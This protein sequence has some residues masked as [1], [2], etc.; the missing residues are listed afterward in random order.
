MISSTGFSSSGAFA[1]LSRKDFRV[2]EKRVVDQLLIEA[3]KRQPCTACGFPGGDAHHV[4]SRGAGG[5]DVPS[6]LM[7]LCRKHH[8]EVHQIGWKKMTQKWP[9][10]R[11]WLERNGR[12]DI[13]ERANR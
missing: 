11:I 4:S 7:A 2:V 3:V 12:I 8:T 6:N 10:V 9:K 5:D 1:K 13:L